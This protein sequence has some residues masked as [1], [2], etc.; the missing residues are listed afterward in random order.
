MTNY[1]KT[2]TEHTK[3]IAS[4]RD[5]LGMEMAKNIVELLFVPI[6]KKKYSR[7]FENRVLYLRKEL[8]K[9]QFMGFRL[10]LLNYSV[11]THTMI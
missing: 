5:C 7:C 8:E 6:K 4:H 1:T 10:I 2:K 9:R 11:S 3:K